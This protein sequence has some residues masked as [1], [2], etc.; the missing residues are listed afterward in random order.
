MDRGRN[1]SYN[2]A[3][4]LEW[5]VRSRSGFKARGHILGRL[6]KQYPSKK[7]HTHYQIH[8]G[9]NQRDTIE[10][11]YNTEFGEMPPLK[12]GMTVEACGDYITSTQ[13][14]GPYP[15]SPDGAILH[16]VHIN[17]GVQGHE[18]GYVLM[19]GKLT[20]TTPPK[21]YRNY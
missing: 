20:G 19:D 17:P 5:K 3:E 9:K 13:K 21:K 15:A 12:V 8:I 4:I 10:L 7:G 11:V 18:H 14:N 1:I 2:N 6:L 16:W